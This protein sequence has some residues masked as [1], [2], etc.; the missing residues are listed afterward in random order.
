MSDFVGNHDWNKKE[1]RHRIYRR[2]K[3]RKREQQKQQMLEL[4]GE[5]FNDV[6]QKKDQKNETRVMEFN[7][8]PPKKA[9]YPLDFLSNQLGRC[10]KTLFL[11][12]EK[13]DDLTKW[14]NQG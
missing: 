7:I 1:K 11:F 13:M 12:N 10:M 6:I 9:V 8:R 2:K 4:L 5:V 3:I 14:K